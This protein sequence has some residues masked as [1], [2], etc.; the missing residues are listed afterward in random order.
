LADVLINN[1]GGKATKG[2]CF[3]KLFKV[4]EN[5]RKLT[6]NFELKPYNKKP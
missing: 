3:V 4:A 6:V 1:N 5:T 2:E